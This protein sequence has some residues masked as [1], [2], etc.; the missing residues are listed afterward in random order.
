MNKYIKNTPIKKNFVQP[1]V[2]KMQDFGVKVFIFRAN[3][4]VIYAT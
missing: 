3:A 4:Y 1:W 2:S